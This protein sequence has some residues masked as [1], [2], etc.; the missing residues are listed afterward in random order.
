MSF[1]LDGKIAIDTTPGF[2]GLLDHVPHGCKV[3][4][5]GAVAHCLATCRLNLS[6][7]GLCTCGTST[8]VAQVIDHDFRTVFG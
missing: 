1:R 8:I 4:D 6:D 2:H 7:D 3:S 5:I